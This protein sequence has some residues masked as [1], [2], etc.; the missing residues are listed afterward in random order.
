MDLCPYN[1]VA[2]S[3]G[4]ISK[5]CGLFTD[6]EWKDYD[7]FQSLGKYYGYS[8]G[9]PL[10]PPQGVGWTNELIARLTRTPVHDHT[11][12]NS[13]LDADPET[14]PLG[15]KLYADFSHDN[16]MMMIFSA[17]GLF[18]STRPLETGRRMSKDEMKGFSAAA[19]VPFA[20]RMYVEKL[21][22]VRAEEGEKEEE[23]V[24]VLVNDQVMELKTCGGDE[25]GRCRLGAFVESL[26]Y[27]RGG[28]DWEKCFL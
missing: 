22:C 11:S 8:W 3:K 17:L 28:G 16:D 24:R 12:T 10:A 14:F 26:G 23:W 27:A 21:R 5:F 13:T 6:E 7:Y 9:N 20:S 1:T 19:A 2:S 15:E 25:F 4:S 18:N